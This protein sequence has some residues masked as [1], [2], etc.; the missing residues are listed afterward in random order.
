MKE[1][2]FMFR[3][4]IIF[5]YVV[6]ILG[7]MQCIGYI[8]Y[9]LLNRFGYVTWHHYRIKTSR[10]YRKEIQKSF[11]LKKYD[12]MDLIVEKTIFTYISKMLD[13]KLKY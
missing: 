4:V 3:D 11:I 1:V 10:C 7:T 12:M 2:V 8:G 9:N 6:F 13:K 5:L